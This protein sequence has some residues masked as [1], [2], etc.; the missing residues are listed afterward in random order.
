MRG[1]YEVD[2]TVVVVI[3]RLPT[4]TL[5]WTISLHPEAEQGSTK[6]QELDTLARGIAIPVERMANGARRY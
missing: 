1:W 5:L 4:R 2:R 6:C 3:Q